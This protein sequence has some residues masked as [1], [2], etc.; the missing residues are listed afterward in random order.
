D[1]ILDR[2]NSAGLQ[3]VE[4]LGFRAR[5]LAELGCS[6]VTLDDSESTRESKQHPFGR[7]CALEVSQPPGHPELMAVMVRLSINCGQDSALYIF[8]EMAGVWRLLIGDEGANYESIEDARESLNYSVSP[9]DTGGG[10]FVAV[11]TIGPACIGS[12]RNLWYRVLRPGPE[13]YEPRAILDKKECIWLGSDP[14]YTL[15]ARAGGFT[16]DFFAPRTLDTG[17]RRHIVKYQIAGDQAIRVAPLAE[18][19]EDFLDEWSS[20]PWDEASRWVTKGAAVDLKHIHSEL[21]RDQD[22][23][24]GPYPDESPT[25][26]FVQDCGPGDR[27]WQI[28]F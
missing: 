15:Q 19:P 10:F 18:F 28:G 1:F 27:K 11:A 4:P 16:L 14:P 8:R 7:I 25:I 9:F 22:D 23:N 26:A 13:P 12:W 3:P 21:H 2:L 24:D 20:Q 5:I 17:F 6:G